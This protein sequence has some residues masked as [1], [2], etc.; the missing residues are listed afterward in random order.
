MSRNYST[1]NKK[2][3]KKKTSKE[4]MSVENS[5]L[6]GKRSKDIPASKSQN[7]IN[8]EPSQEITEYPGST[9]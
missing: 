3:P 4:R 6:Y 7:N 5:L 1:N 9:F 2:K 8:V